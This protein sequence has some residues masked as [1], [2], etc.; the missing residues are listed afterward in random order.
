P[1]IIAADWADPE[2]PRRDNWRKEVFDAARFDPPLARELLRPL[3]ELDTMACGASAVWFIVS[4]G[5]AERV[6]GQPGAT[7][8]FADKRTELW[9]VPGR[10]CP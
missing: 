5:H 8:A 1:V 4:A 9:R 6:A 2:I 3:T 10:A 7:R